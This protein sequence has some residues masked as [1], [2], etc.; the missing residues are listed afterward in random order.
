MKL[1]ISWSGELSQLVAILLREWLRHVI[2]VVEPYV[3]SEDIE[4]GSRW[5]VEIDSKLDKCDFSIVCL[6]RDNMIKPWI[7]F[8]AGAVS[9]S[10]SRSRVTP[11]LIDIS[12]ADLSG[13][14]SQFQA[15]SFTETEMLRLVKDIGGYLDDSRLD[16]VL[17]EESFHKWWPD[18]HQRVMQAI[19]S[20]KGAGPREERRSDRDILEELVQLCR[21][22]AQ[23]ISTPS[24]VIEITAPVGSDSMIE[25]LKRELEEQRRMLL[26]TMLEGASRVGFD[27]KELYIEFE[28]NAKHLRDTLAKAE[29]I[30]ILRDAGAKI[31]GRDIG[32]RFVVKDRTNLRRKSSLSEEEVRDRERLRK[33]AESS[34][35]V[36]EMLRTFRGEIKDVRRV[37]E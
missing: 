5:F 22:L 10:I 28:P 8:E 36:Q 3:S 18:L 34:P 25:Q 27:G 30:Q 17:I 14:L 7:H 19:E 11:L 9:R 29:N 15:T 33:M 4:K 24:S 23:L 31:A 35:L 37:D 2:Q 6:T 21:N 1:F 32:V 12:P 20:T 26:V 13:P 16:D